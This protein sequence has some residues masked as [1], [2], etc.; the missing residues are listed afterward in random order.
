MSSAA[1][2]SVANS[3]H[4]LCSR[5]LRAR[6]R[7]ATAQEHELLDR[8]LG[9]LD[10]QSVDC[11]RVFLEANAAALLSLET[12][13][14]RS[15]ISRIFPDWPARS[16]RAAILS[17][18]TAVGGTTRLLPCPASLDFGGV[19]GTMYVLEGSRLGARY[20]LKTVGPSAD[21]S[22]A[23]A[24]AY[25]SHGASQ[26]LWQSFLARLEQLALTPRDEARAIDAA[27]NAFVL[28]TQAAD[29]ALARVKADA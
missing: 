11:Y 12:A 14:E 4:R 3:P 5:G 18:L 25:L 27:Q 2:A 20:L 22:V 28:F 15:G 9:A 8:Q 7:E 6:L 24:T 13:L 19:L 1:V 26:H 23:G 21:A 29:T 10:L 17:D 16:R